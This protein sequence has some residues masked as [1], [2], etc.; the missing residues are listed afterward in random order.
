LSQSSYFT[1]LAA[2]ATRHLDRNKTTSLQRNAALKV[3]AR[4]GESR[5]AF[6]ARVQAAASDRADEE[7]A[8]LR[9][10]YESR[11]RKAKRDYDAAIRS[12]DTAAAAVDADRGD[13][14]LG[15]GLDL[16]MGRKPKRSSSKRSTGQLR[17]A[18]DKVERT[19]VAYE[20]LAADL[21]DEL[22][23]IEDSWA[24][25]AQDVETLE[26]GLEADDIRV[27]HT[28]VFWVRT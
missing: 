14:I 27:T 21:D 10:K 9:G 26:V 3:T 8:K 1:K 24:A 13:A 23:A 20:D 5:E 28:R 17:K 19:R 22:R 15:M 2:A 4:P 25:K 12:A 16:L 6:A 11:F 7:M 18:E